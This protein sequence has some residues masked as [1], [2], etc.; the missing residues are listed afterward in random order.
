VA[1]ELGLLG[2]GGG[3]GLMLVQMPPMLPAPGPRRPPPPPQQQDPSRFTTAE[4][5]SAAPSPL[6]LSMEQMRAGKVG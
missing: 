4:K 2:D 6:A 1:R 3:E 5:A